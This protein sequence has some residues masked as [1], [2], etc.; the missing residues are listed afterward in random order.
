MYDL[1]PPITPQLA[2]WPQDTSPTRE[3]LLRISDGDSVTLST[4]RS[5]THLGSH[6]DGPNHYLAEG[7]GVG[8]QP[9]EHYLGTCRV[10]PVRATPGE[11]YDHTSLPSGTPIDAPR[12]LLATGCTSPPE[13]FE[14]NFPAPDP[15]LID[16]LA[17]RGVITLGVDTPSVDLFPS[18]DLPTHH[19]CGDRGVR[20]LEGLRLGPVPPG[21]YELIALPLRLMGFDASPVRAVLR[22]LPDETT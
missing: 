4:L 1:S 3:V 11:R 16:F 9:L 18:K 15:S 8:E 13:T 2:V 17:D 20:I 12:I 19:R 5:T 21:R 6:A 22:P 10:I 7:E 14:E